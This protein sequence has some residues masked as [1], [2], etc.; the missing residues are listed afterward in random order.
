MFPFSP[1]PR[2]RVDRGVY[3]VALGFIHFMISFPLVSSL[4]FWMYVLF[5][6]F[7]FDPFYDFF[8]VS[9]LFGFLDV[10]F[11]VALR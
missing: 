3:L 4:A 8:S 10:C 1:F 5:S 11:S 6:G 7:R 2:D 9:F